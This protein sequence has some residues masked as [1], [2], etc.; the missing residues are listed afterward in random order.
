M[1][2]SSI[3]IPAADETAPKKFRRP[4]NRRERDTLFPLV[5]A[6]LGSQGSVAASK[7]TRELLLQ[8]RV[9]VQGDAIRKDRGRRDNA[10]SSCPTQKR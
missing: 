3:A 8:I 1:L 9:H 4:F 6:A 2:E 5:V 7:I 10:R